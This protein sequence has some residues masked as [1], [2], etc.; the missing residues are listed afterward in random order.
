[1]IAWR[2]TC[3]L[4]Q[5]LDENDTAAFQIKEAVKPDRPQNAYLAEETSLAV[6]V[7]MPRVICINGSRDFPALHGGNI[8][9]LPQNR[10]VLWPRDK[11]V[12]EKVG[13]GVQ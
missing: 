2:F 9:C 13:V 6:A 4:Y 3:P 8:S 5:G 7:L 11:Q 12:L 1:M 10:F